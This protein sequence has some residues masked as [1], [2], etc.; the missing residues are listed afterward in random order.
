MIVPA[1]PGGSYDLHARLVARYIAR[2]IPG[3]PAVAVNNMT[4]AGGL[5][6]INYLY[7]KAPQD[8]TALGIP[9]QENVL[10][11]VLG[12]QDVRPHRVERRLQ[13]NFRPELLHL[14]HC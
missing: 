2:F 9:V 5:R 1:H 3:R 6:A 11:D 4:G 8:C 7:E 14:H 13:T 10:A 12:G